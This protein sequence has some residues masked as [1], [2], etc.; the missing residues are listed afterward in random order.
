M[1]FSEKFMEFLQM[2]TTNAPNDPI[3]DNA[4]VFIVT[5]DGVSYSEEGIEYIQESLKELFN[6]TKNLT[7]YT[8]KSLNK[9]K[10]FLEYITYKK[11]T[12]VVLS[13]KDNIEFVS[14]TSID[15]LYE[16]IEEGHEERPE[17][18]TWQIMMLSGNLELY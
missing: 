18:T 15:R 4:A 3:G 1:D 8:G 12:Y 14:S 13:H 5:R 11:E 9:P 2:E 16:A 7:I 6:V 10:I 17:L